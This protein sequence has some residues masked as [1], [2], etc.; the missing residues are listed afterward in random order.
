MDPEYQGLGIRKFGEGLSTYFMKNIEY[1]FFRY[2]LENKGK[3]PE[4]VYV[5]A[6]GSDEWQT[7]DVWPSDDIAFTPMYL[8]G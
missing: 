4:P 6:S 1:Q 7:M 2:Y 8:S 3:R 5:F